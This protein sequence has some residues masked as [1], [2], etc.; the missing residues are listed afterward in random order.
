ME[1]QPLIAIVGPT[2]VGKSALALRLAQ[3]FRGEIVSADSRQIYR[4]MD[5]GTA[6]P[7]AAERQRV[8][9]HLIDLVNPNVTFTL[10]EYQRLAYAVI[11]QIHARGNVPFL[12]GGTGL[13]VR[14]VLE[15][16]TIPRVAPNPARRQE[17]ECQDA[18]TLYARLRQLD[19]R[20][21][22]RIDPRNKRRVIRALEVCEAAGAPIS[23]LQQTRAPNYRI[24][25]IGLTMPREQLYARIHARVEQMLAAGLIEEVR[26]LLARGYAPTLPAMSGLGYRHIAA[27]LNGTLTR[28]EALRLL[29]RDT[30]RFA[31]HQYSWFRLDDARI[32]WHNLAEPCD[33]AIRATVAEFLAPGGTG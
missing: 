23:A 12:V 29:Q 7:N 10:A 26:A 21:A 8:P 5:I 2:A 18:A 27:Y 11:A 15:G 20:A 16:L 24:L 1:A 3:E 14:A 6:K 28:A 30:R 33:A 22:A 19:P 13:Y 31:R 4:G 17:L 32:R 9:H 25:R